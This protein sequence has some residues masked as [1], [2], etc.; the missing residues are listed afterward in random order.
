[1][2]AEIKTGM[3]NQEPHKSKR[4]SSFIWILVLWG[5]VRLFSELHPIYWTHLFFGVVVD[6]GLIPVSVALFISMWVKNAD[7]EKILRWTAFGILVGISFF[8]VLLQA[9]GISNFRTVLVVIHWVLLMAGILSAYLRTSKKGE[10]HG[11]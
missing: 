10:A 9:L 7:S 4:L 11:Y 5:T 1:M 8:G 6:S 2:S 3:A